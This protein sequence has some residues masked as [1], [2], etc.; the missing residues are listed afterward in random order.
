[1]TMDDP[2]SSLDLGVVESNRVSPSRGG[3]GPKPSSGYGSLEGN[4]ATAGGP[5]EDEDSPWV[6]DW[7]NAM[8]DNEIKKWLMKMITTYHWP[9]QS[10]A[11]MAADLLDELAEIGAYETKGRSNLV[12]NTP[13]N[14]KPYWSVWV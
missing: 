12:R 13:L 5:I 3:A 4:A 1:M 7:L 6:T 14:K 9:E 8:P 10:Q 11:M 2:G